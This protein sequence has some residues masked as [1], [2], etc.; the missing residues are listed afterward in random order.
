MDTQAWKNR[1]NAL[2]DL[3]DQKEIIKLIRFVL[4][5]NAKH[6]HPTK[7]DCLIRDVESFIP[8]II[9]HWD[10][11]RLVDGFIAAINW[12]YTKWQLVN[13]VAH[14]DVAHIN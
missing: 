12:Q 2:E 3:E 5:E 7:A 6:L 1:R 11:D 13:A 14:S 4:N 9:M 8:A 10:D